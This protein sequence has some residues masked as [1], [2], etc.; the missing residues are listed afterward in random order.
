MKTK[1]INYRKVLHSSVRRFMER[2]EDFS[3]KIGI[4]LVAGDYLGKKEKR[5][6]VAE[7]MALWMCINPD[8]QFYNKMWEKVSP[9]GKHYSDGYYGGAVWRRFQN[10]RD[11]QV[12]EISSQLASLEENSKNAWVRAVCRFMLLPKDVVRKWLWHENVDFQSCESFLRRLTDE[13]HVS[14]KRHYDL[15]KARTAIKELPCF[16]DGALNKV[17]NFFGLNAKEE[18][19]RMAVKSA[20]AHD[21]LGMNMG[22]ALYSNAEDDHVVK[23]D[24]AEQFLSK[25]DRGQ[26][27]VNKEHGGLYWFL[28]RALRSNPLWREGKHVELGAWICPG[29]WFTMI[30]WGILTLVSPA[31]LLVATGLYVFKGTLSWVLFGL[32]AI[33]PIVVM[34]YWVKKLCNKEYNDEYWL[35]FLKGVFFACLILLAHMALVH[36]KEFWSVASGALCLIFLVPY[37]IKND[38]LDFWDAPIL[39][40]LLPSVFLMA[41]AWDI[42]VHSDFWFY[43]AGFIMSAVTE[44]WIFA[45]HVV[46]TI[47]EMRMMLLMAVVVVAAYAGLLVALFHLSD[48][49]ARKSD[50]LIEKGD[51]RAY[52]YESRV[53]G[54]VFVVMMAIFLTSTYRMFSS[55]P[56]G[57]EFL[58]LVIT[59]IP[60]LFFL[61]YCAMNRVEVKVN[62]KVTRSALLY[63][64]V[65]D[66]E[67][68][69]IRHAIACNEFWS[70]IDHAIVRAK[71]L[72]RIL[73]KVSSRSDRCVWIAAMIR[74]VKSDAEF[75]NMEHFALSEL[76]SELG[77]GHTRHFVDQEV[78]SLILSGA[79]DDVIRSAVVSAREKYLAISGKL[80]KPTAWSLL[81]SRFSDWL[82]ETAIPFGVKC[83]GLVTWPFRMFW[84]AVCDLH[85]IW[86]S[87][88][89]Q[90]PKA[91]PRDRPVAQ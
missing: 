44:V 12:R 52:N 51:R 40:K 59:L 72:N 46:Q 21:F 62:K 67:Q 63:L 1:Q 22:F 64:T 80:K 24:L 38:T 89:E 41:G 70:D 37:C 60:F 69:A 42:H 6:L 90:C 17:W 26:F 50:E 77:F 79:S 81:N 36:A 27:E 49:L 47:Y 31:S 68:V 86:E 14:L 39:G 4:K 82:D 73:I 71:V 15:V 32:G 3:A 66:D 11:A 54:A 55:V 45:Q 19:N 43:F 2:P 30:L 16:T 33:L 34:A 84:K 87:F 78:I 61:A 48:Y 10:A 8:S 35:F 18:P 91:P 9:K 58:L 7:A 5:A 20:M 13:Q 74:V 28:Y 83:W 85:T 53:L 65:Y 75:V 25:Q 76:Y 88:N 56:S 57:A 29:F 23:K